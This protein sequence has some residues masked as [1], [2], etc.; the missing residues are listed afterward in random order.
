[1]KTRIRIEH[2]N[3]GEIFYTPQAKTNSLVVWHNIQQDNSLCT[4]TKV[5]WK[6]K[7]NAEKAIVDYL[8]Y[9]DRVNGQKV[10]FIEY[11]TFNQQ[12]QWNKQQ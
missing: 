11:E 3:N 2:R 9:V 7:E 6:E 8:E 10:K 4:T 12:E 1:M 5:F